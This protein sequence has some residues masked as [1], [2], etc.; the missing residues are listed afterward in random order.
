MP[1]NWWARVGIGGGLGLVTT[2][3]SAFFLD[4]WMIPAA[5][6]A[7]VAAIGFLATFFIFNPDIAPTPEY[8]EGYEQVLFDKP[9]NIA[10]GA[11]IV[12][13][14]TLAFFVRFDV[15]PGPDPAAYLAER[16]GMI[17]DLEDFRIL[18][19]EQVAQFNAGALSKADYQVALQ[20]QVNDLRPFV[21]RIETMDVPDQFADDFEALANATV[22]LYQ[23]FEARDFCLSDIEARCQT[24]VDKFEQG[25]AALDVLTAPPEEEEA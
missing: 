5:A 15:D 9:N 12:L 19:E 20:A 22:S 24:A 7:A 23:A 11:L 18:Y 21:D 16:N 4:G 25:K 13:M 17:T 3:G 8:P 14:L 6:G 10:S 1:M 2:L